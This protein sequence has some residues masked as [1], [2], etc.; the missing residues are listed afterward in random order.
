MLGHYSLARNGVLHRDI[1]VDN[2]MYFRKPNGEVAGVLNDFD[3]AI[4]IGFSRKSYEKT[5]TIPFMAHQLLL[6]MKDNV[7]RPHIYGVLV[8][9][10]RSIS[11]F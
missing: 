7:P 3:L 4:V 5:G 1:S 10:A 8:P 9:I 6:S 11:Q 2:L